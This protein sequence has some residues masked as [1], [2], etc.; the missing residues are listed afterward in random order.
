MDKNEIVRKYKWFR[1]LRGIPE[2]FFY[3]LFCFIIPV[4][5]SI[6]MFIIDYFL[7]LDLHMMVL[8]IPYIVTLFI[9]FFWELKNKET[10]ENFII[11]LS[12]H[13]TFTHHFEKKWG[14]TE[15]EIKEFISKRNFLG[16]NPVKYVFPFIRELCKLNKG[17]K[18]VQEALLSDFL[19]KKEIEII[20]D[21]F[22]KLGSLEDAIL[23][24][25]KR[26]GPE[27]LSFMHF[28]FKLAIVQDGI[29][30]DEWNM[31]MNLT[32]QLRFSYYYREDF[33]Y[34]YFSL[35]TEF[36]DYERK[37]STSTEDHSASTNNSSSSLKPYFTILG[38]EETASDEEIKRAYRNL[39]L[40]HHPDMPKNADRIK[41]CEAMMAK[42][43]EAYEKLNRYSSLR[44]E[45]YDYERKSS[46]STEDNSASTNNSS[47]SLKPYFTILGLEE[48]ASDEEI[49]RA[50]RNLVLQHHPDMPKNADRI[51]ECEAMMAKI[52]EAYEKLRG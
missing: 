30:N 42:I 23:Y 8:E 38:L 45:F 51:K 31:L 13:V 37:S 26:S 12:N 40:Q 44:T 49:K 33:R 4:C 18:D 5:I 3:M 27:R 28:L 15:E 46:T 39:V 50:Y 11:S 17:A 21:D 22:Q 32:W 48:T 14:M 19:S 47:S 35:R 24:W 34:R 20:F 10:I 29:H 7:D 41:E 9:I 36:Y 2:R 52:N 25:L 16:R 1:V 6:F 43:N